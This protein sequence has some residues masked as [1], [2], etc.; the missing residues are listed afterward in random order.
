MVTLKLC[1]SQDPASKLEGVTK[2]IEQ[3]RSG[4]TIKLES[5]AL[6][7]GHFAAFTP[8]TI[9]LKECPIVILKNRI[10]RVD[11]IVDRIS[12]QVTRKKIPNSCHYFPR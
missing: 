11:R 4:F 8:K 5:L 2:Y 1:A 12:L 10:A 6:F 3:L 9:N 7:S